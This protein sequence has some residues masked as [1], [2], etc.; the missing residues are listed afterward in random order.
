LN[1]KD[2]ETTCFELIGGTVE[3]STNIAPFEQMGAGF[4]LG[5]V[6]L[7]SSV[8]QSKDSMGESAGLCRT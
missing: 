4:L 2:A 6:L 7:D 3:P 5:N 1:P 8:M